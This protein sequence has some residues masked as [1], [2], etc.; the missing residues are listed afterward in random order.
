MSIQAPVPDTIR[1][2][3]VLTDLIMNTHTAAEKS[4]TDRKLEDLTV[5]DKFRL[6]GLEVT[7][8]DT[9]IDAA[10]AFVLTLLV[11][12]FDDIPSNISEML[13]A[14]KRIPGF[15]ASYAILMMFWLQHRK[16]SRR[17]GLENRR[18]I[19]HSLMLIFVMLVYVYPLRMFFEGLFSNLTGGYLST[20]YQIET[21]NDL[22]LIFAFYSS[23]FLAMSLLVSQLYRLAMHNSVSLRLNSIEL[24]KTKVDMH[25]WAIAT[26]FGL[27]S[28]LMT[29]TLPDPWVLAAGY[30]YFAML[31]ILQ[32][33]SFLDR[34]RISNAS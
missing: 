2:Y 7:R 24:R 6:R 1:R 12:S 28:I 26:S 23:G 15:A 11:I 20:S 13:A 14:V 10:F 16:W 5:E 22:R 9:F 4:W 21:Y 33:P 25:V 3:S 34:R 32:I 17:Y 8:L 19:L 30:M 18:T 27:L 29:L 31:P